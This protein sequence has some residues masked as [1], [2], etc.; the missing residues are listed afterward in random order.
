ML[1]AAGTKSDLKFQNRMQPSLLC[2]TLAFHGFYT[3]PL[4]TNKLLKAIVFSVELPV[5]QSSDF[6][7]KTEL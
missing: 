4:Q 3:K 5:E 2:E 1:D 7:T 6:L